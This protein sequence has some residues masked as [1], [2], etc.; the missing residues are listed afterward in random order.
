[1]Y[2]TELN[3]Y[4]KDAKRPST[5]KTL[6]VSSTTRSEMTSTQPQGKRQANTEQEN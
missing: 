5:T 2:T 3:P 1:M 4:D 6:P